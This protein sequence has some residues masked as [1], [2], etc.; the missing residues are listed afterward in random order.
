MMRA[1][2]TFKSSA[3]LFDAG[4]AVMSY[5]IADNTSCWRFKGESFETPRIIAVEYADV[6]GSQI[7]VYPMSQLVKNA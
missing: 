2:K 4:Y 3:E 7:P 1:M 6:N 5:S